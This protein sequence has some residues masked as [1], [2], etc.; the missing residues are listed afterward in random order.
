MSLL[1]IAGSILEIRSTPKY[2]E[3]EGIKIISFSTVNKAGFD[4]LLHSFKATFDIILHNRAD[5]IHIHSGANSIWALF[6]RLPENKY[7]SVSLQW[8]GNE[9]N[10]HGTG[11][12]S[13]VFKLFDCI[14][15]D[16]L[17]LIIYLQKSIFEKKFKRPLLFYSL[18][19]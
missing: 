10:G 17:F 11:N 3:Y 18:R 14:F 16:G 9:I 12:F 7:I 15:S 2:S 6:L 5:V 19:I 13:T 1:P 8:T 4:T